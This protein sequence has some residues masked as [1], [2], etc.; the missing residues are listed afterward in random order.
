MGIGRR[1]RWKKRICNN[2]LQTNHNRRSNSNNKHN[3][4]SRILQLVR[5][6]CS[7]S[8]SS[9]NS[10]MRR[11]LKLIKG[12]IKR[13]SWRMI[14]VSL[15]KALRINWGR[16]IYS[17]NLEDYLITT[18]TIPFS[19]SNSNNSLMYKLRSNMSNLSKSYLNWRVIIKKYNEL[20]SITKK[21][22]Q[23]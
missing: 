18:T 15:N 6:L 20:N 5:H 23:I 22:L 8:S 21:R 12:P 9:S 7:S 11:C 2:Q 13:D 10:K 3:S 14:R 17:N 16:I 19:Y 4:I 1:K